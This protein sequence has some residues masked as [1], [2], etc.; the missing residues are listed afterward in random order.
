MSNFNTVALLMALAIL[1]LFLNIYV[2]RTVSDRGETILTGVV[3]GVP[4]PTEARRVVLHTL[5]MRAASGQVAIHFIFSVMW[6]LLGR[7]ASSE[8]VRLLC[9]LFA[10]LGVTGIFFSILEGVSWYRLLQ[11][12]LRQAESGSTAGR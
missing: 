10:F 8:E 9:Y 12:V 4:V 2:D 3:R 7:N 1:N 11:S 5:W 6:L